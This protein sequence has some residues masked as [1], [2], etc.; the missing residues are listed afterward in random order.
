MKADIHFGA[1]DAALPDWR[2]A[3]LK[4]TEDND[5]VLRPTPQDVIDILGF[6]PL[7]FEED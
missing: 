4:D 7:E 2:K 3:K 1:V 6:D 5:E